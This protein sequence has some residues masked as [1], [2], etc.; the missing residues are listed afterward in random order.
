ML[1]GTLIGRERSRENKNRS[2]WATS[3]RPDGLRF[4][5]LD[6]RTRSSETRDDS[7]P[8]P[9]SS[10]PVHVAGPFLAFARWRT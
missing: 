1:S 5:D 7:G 4:G 3:S 10:T 6:G 9:P 2:E 8:V